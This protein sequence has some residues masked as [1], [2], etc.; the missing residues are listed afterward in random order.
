MAPHR[1]VCWLLL[2]PELLRGQPG[3]IDATYNTGDLGAGIGSTFDGRVFL[4]PLNP[5]TITCMALGP[6]NKTVFGGY[7][8]CQGFGPVIGRVSVRNA[9]GSFDQAFLD[10]SSPILEGKVTCVAMQADGKVLVGGRFFVSGLGET[11][12]IRVNANASVDLSFADLTWNPVAEIRCIAIRS[13]GKILIGG[14]FGSSTSYP[15]FGHLALLNATG[16]TAPCSTPNGP[17]NSISVLA[18]NTAIVAGEFSTLGGQTRHNIAKITANGIV[19]PSFGSSLFTCNGAIRCTVIQPDGMIV[20][21][22]DFTYIYPSTRNRIARYNADGVLD[23]TFD[24]GPGADAAVRSVALGFNG[25]IL[26]AGDFTTLRGLSEYSFGA[27][28]PTGD[29]ANGFFTGTGP[30]G[31]VH[32]VRARSDGRILLAGEFT[33]YNGTLAYKHT[34]LLLHGTIDGSFANNGASD[35]VRAISPLPDGSAFIAGQFLGVNGVPRRHLAKLRPDGSVD[36]AF[37]PEHLDF[38]ALGPDATSI[39]VEDIAVDPTGGVLVAG[40][41]RHD[42][43]VFLAPDPRCVIRFHP[44]GDIDTTFRV[45]QVAFPTS[46]WFLDV[47]ALPDGRVL[48]TS[49]DGKVMRLLNNGALDST[50]TVAAASM[51]NGTRRI[52]MHVCP[53]GQILVYGNFSNMAGSALNNVVRLNADGTLDQ[54]FIQGTGFNGAMNNVVLRADGKVI[55]SGSFTQYNGQA[56][57]GLARLNQDGTLDNTFTAT[58]AGG[59]HLTLLP[60]DKVLVDARF[61]LNEDGT[62]DPSWAGGTGCNGPI[63]ASYATPQGVLIVGDFTA[64]KTHNKNRYTRIRTG[65]PAATQLVV[66]VILQ[67]PYDS[68]ND[69]MNDGLRASGLVPMTEPYGDMGYQH[70]GGLPAATTGAV[71]SVVGNDAI[72][73]WVMLETRHPDA[74]DFITSTRPA[75]LQRDGDVVALDGVSPVAIASPDQSA[76]VAVRHRNHLGIM[77]ASPLTLTSPTSNWD[78]S[79]PGTPVFGTNARAEVNGRSAMWGGD[80]NNDGQVKYTGTANDRDAVLVAVGG[81][82]PTSTSAGY[83]VQD[84]DLDGMVKYTGVDNDRDPI[85]VNIG[86]SIPTAVR[87]QQLP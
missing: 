67:G 12:L 58:I 52:R 62:V 72:V 2:I 81:Y 45:R 29:S 84:V 10:S 28:G 65:T 56:V 24:P 64:Y 23:S 5:D 31:P 42:D 50:F 85:L 4:H 9:D 7:S 11:C 1:I 38:D 53:D 39:S 61:L 59:G 74:P 63:L 32:T 86:G 49:Q 18:D 13:D 3:S 75:L 14:V 25:R 70:I 57:G 37:V 33:E 71:L 87:V 19:V 41:I 76:Y 54:G 82:L 46:P 6:G 26:L 78:A 77:S 30:N 34:R 66:R 22:G 51:P 35:I 40:L 55:A 43:G 48:A 17:V 68:N 15:V 60:G 47:E 80:V 8:C 44:N 79:I 69:L 36:P 83:L 27:L 20:V 73:D 21:G 16:S